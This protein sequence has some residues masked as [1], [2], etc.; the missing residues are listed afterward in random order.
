MA[1]PQPLAQTHP[2]E[3]WGAFGAACSIILVLVT[4]LYNRLNRD[5]K[6]CNTR[7]DNGQQAFEDIK[8]NQGRMDERMKV[9]DADFESVN[10]E[11]DRLDNSDRD[12]DGRLK[13]IEVEHK[14]CIPRKL[15]MRGMQREEI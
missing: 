8:V 6:D 10:E 9:I 7:L 11:L 2:A 5:I 3:V 15:A 1:D 4:V 14:G 12:I 13:T